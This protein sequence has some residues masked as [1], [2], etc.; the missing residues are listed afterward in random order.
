MAKLGLRIL[1]AQVVFLLSTSGGYKKD[2]E[3]TN[4]ETKNLISEH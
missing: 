2:S 1:D 4:Q 3:A